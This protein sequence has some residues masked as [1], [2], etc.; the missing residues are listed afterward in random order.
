MKSKSAERS[1]AM[2]AVAGT[3]LGLC[4]AAGCGAPANDEDIPPQRLTSIAEYEAG[5][6]VKLKA[7]AGVTV[8]RKD[9]VDVNNLKNLVGSRSFSPRN[10]PFALLGVEKAFEFSERRTARPGERLHGGI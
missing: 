5:A 6:A 3:A 8:Q 7:D 2:F 10:D 4:L 1:L 9:G